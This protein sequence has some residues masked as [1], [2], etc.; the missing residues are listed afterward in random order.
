MCALLRPPPIAETT[1]FLM[2]LLFERRRSKM[3]SETLPLESRNSERPLGQL[4]FSWEPIN[5]YFKMKGEY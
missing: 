4:W 3:P 5:W 1:D 2:V